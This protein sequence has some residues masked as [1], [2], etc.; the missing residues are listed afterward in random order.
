MDMEE[1]VSQTGS[2]PRPH[3]ARGKGFSLLLAALTHVG[4]IVICLSAIYTLQPPTLPTRRW[5]G[6]VVLAL[7]MLGNAIVSRGRSGFSV[8]GKLLTALAGGIVLSLAGEPQLANLGNLGETLP[9]WLVSL[10]PSIA[11]VALVW[12]VTFGL[13]YL[14]ASNADR[15]QRTTP[16]L[17]GLHASGLLVLV[18]GLVTFFALTRLYPIDPMY[19]SLLIS[20]ALQ[21]YLLLLVLVSISGRIGVGSS[22]ELYMAVTLLLA[23]ARNILGPHGEQ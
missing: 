17:G 15:A 19:L 3:P 1:Q 6:L 23:C 13:A 21:Y 9:P 18:L 12:A 7:V 11:T 5:A 10:Y 16:F 22:I 2:L 8:N 20:N 14:R 4:L